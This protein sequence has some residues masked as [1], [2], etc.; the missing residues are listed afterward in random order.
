M[1]T[2]TRMP[3]WDPQKAAIGADPAVAISGTTK[4]EI[5]DCGAADG[6]LKI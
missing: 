3:H 5:M 2:I 1:N 4:D 6:L